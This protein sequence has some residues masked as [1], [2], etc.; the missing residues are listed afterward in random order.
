MQDRCGSCLIY[1]LQPTLVHSKC[2]LASAQ[3]MTMDKLS[4]GAALQASGMHSPLTL[5]KAQSATHAQQRIAVLLS[6]SHPDY[7]ATM[8]ELKA[9]FARHAY[10]YNYY[11]LR[12]ACWMMYQLS[13]ACSKCLAI[14]RR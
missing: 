12:K 1:V 6:Y 7:Y 14:M 13:G 9:I 4:F 11:Y 2:A 3:G 8:E 5:S 10:H